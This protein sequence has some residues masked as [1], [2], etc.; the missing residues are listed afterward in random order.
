MLPWQYI[1]NHFTIYLHDHID[2]VADQRISESIMRDNV[3]PISSLNNNNTEESDS[4][5]MAKSEPELEEL[6][7]ESKINAA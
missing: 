5:S 6:E 1:R 7:S 3:I 2:G 4:I